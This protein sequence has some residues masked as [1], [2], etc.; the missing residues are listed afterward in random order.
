MFVLCTVFMIISPMYVLKRNISF[1][2]LDFFLQQCKKVT[3][4][5]FATGLLTLPCLQHLQ[6][7]LQELLV[8]LCV[9]PIHPTGPGHV[10]PPI[11]YETIGRNN[12][13]HRI[14]QLRTTAVE[15][16]PL[17]CSFKLIKKLPVDPKSLIHTRFKTRLN[18]SWG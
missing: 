16:F 18:A 3:D 17:K 15:N 9:N 10:H 2:L 14:Q 13:C 1:P 4:V 7:S 8:A 11:R 6:R 12:N 5:T